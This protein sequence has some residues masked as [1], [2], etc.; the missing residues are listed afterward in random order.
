VAVRLCGEL[1]RSDDLSGARR[2]YRMHEDDGVC[3]PDE[4]AR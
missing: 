1:A 4:G 2:L 3:R